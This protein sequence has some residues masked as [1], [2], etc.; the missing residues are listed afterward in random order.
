MQCT[1]ELNACRLLLPSLPCCSNGV[2]DRAELQSLLER[3]GGG[4][5]EVPLVRVYFVLDGNNVQGGLGAVAQVP[6]TAVVRQQRSIAAGCLQLQHWLTDADVDEDGPAFANYWMV[7]HLFLLLQH[8]LTDEDVDEVI[9]QYDTNK[10][11]VIK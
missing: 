8:W 11:G 7:L 1:P 9:A 6:R 2:I 4:S 10:D 5:D 3:V